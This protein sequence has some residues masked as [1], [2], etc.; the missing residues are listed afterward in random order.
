ML[1]GHYLQHENADTAADQLTIIKQWN[2]L[3]D[4]VLRNFLVKYMYPALEKQ[5]REDLTK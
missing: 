5:I 3:R 1:K 4:E 2:I